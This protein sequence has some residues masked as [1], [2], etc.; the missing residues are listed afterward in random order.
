MSSTFFPNSVA[1]NSNLTRTA[2]WKNRR[3]RLAQLRKQAPNRGRTRRVPRITQRSRGLDLG[4]AFEGQSPPLGQCGLSS[5]NCS[6]ICK[7]KR[8]R[9][10][11]TDDGR[12]C[13]VLSSWSCD[14]L[15]VRNEQV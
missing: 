4:R 5:R 11:R 13:L 15:E 9:A 1:P 6:L 2:R 8:F 7:H 14:L 12:E 3:R 10:T